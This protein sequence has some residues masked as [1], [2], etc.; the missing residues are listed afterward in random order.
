MRVALY[1]SDQRGV[2]MARVLLAERMV[3]QLGVFEDGGTH[4]RIAR[5]QD[6]GE[7]DVLV[8]DE[9][10]S[11]GREL[12]DEALEARIDIVTSPP[13]PDG[14]DSGQSTVIHS[15]GHPSSLALALAGESAGSG[16]VM[17]TLVAWTERG[18]GLR[19]G[20]AVS[21]PA[22]IGSRWAEATELGDAP[23]GTRVLKAPGDDEFTGAYAR[24]TMATDLGVQT[25]TTAVADHTDFLAALCVAA[26]TLAIGEG[27][28]G[29][30]VQR[31]GD[32]GGSFLRSAKRS[33]L[34]A[35][36][37]VQSTDA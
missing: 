27:A 16:A 6:V 3:D 34:D 12:L 17:G 28:Y 18:R 20:E 13:I 8:I 33:G 24:T 36:R 37:L 14:L 5:V 11:R 32:H 23:P 30:G 21:F 10:D 25:T 15:A 22:P 26:A 2:R 7:F 29:S 1:A 19:T 4:R 31:P 9:F 35:A